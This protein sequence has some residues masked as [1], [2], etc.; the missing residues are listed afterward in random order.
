[1]AMRERDGKKLNRGEVGK[2]IEERKD[3]FRQGLC[4]VE[5]GG[6]G[7]SDGEKSVC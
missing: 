4:Q 2:I 5:K 7:K 1:M 3:V 6:R